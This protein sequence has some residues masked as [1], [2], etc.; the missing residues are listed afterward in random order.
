MAA[1]PAPTAAE[2]AFAAGYK[3]K[4]SKGYRYYWGVQ[5]RSMMGPAVEGPGTGYVRFHVEI[6]P[7]GKLAKLETL[8]STSDAAERLARQAIEH[9]PSLPPTPSGQPLVFERTISL[10]TTPS[11]FPPI[12][13]DDCLPDPPPSRDAFVWDGKSPLVYEAP[14]PVE[15]PDPAALAECLK[16]LPQDSVEAEAAHGQQE[17]NQWESSDSKH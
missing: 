8:W 15:K 9:M 3:L 12:Y 17:I 10:T 6:A 2:W 13:R 4:N 1:P 14:K 7:D 16:Q 11:G 5:V